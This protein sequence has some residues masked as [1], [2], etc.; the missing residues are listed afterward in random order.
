MTSPARRTRNSMVAIFAAPTAIALVS[1]VGLVAGLLGGG[2]HDLLSWVGLGVPAAV[3][4]W[5]L[6]L[7]RR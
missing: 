1:I 7:R 2:W 6:A 5:S 4:L 3:I